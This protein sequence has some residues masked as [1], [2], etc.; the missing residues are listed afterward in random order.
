MKLIL[1]L[2]WT[3]AVYMIISFTELD[4]NCMNWHLVTRFIF[5]F[6]GPITGSLLIAKS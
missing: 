1:I 4:I 3:I 5:I 2:I 6:L